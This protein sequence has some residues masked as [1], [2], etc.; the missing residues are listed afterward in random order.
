VTPP[1]SAARP[2]GVICMHDSVSLSLRR[3]RRPAGRGER[4]KG[5]KAPLAG[6]VPGFVPTY[7]RTPAPC[8]LASLP[9]CL[10][11]IWV[12]RPGPAH[13]ILFRTMISVRCWESG[14]PTDL[15][16]IIGCCRRRPYSR[17][18]NIIASIAAN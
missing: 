14:T 3:P 18:P 17:Q 1:A 10:L 11:A 7:A 9:P 4:G 2:F 16:P 13:H 8:L 5:G 15:P 6:S 12:L